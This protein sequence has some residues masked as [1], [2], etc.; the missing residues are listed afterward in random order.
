MYHTLKG[1]L[2]LH[3]APVETPSGKSAVVRK[4][5]TACSVVVGQNIEK[6]CQLLR[7][8]RTGGLTLVCFGE[9]LP[10]PGRSFGK[11]L[12]PSYQ[13]LL[14]AFHCRRDNSEIEI[15]DE[16]MTAQSCSR[17]YE[18]I[19]LPPKHKDEKDEVKSGDHMEPGR[20]RRPK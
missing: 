9:G 20:Q 5:K 19:I 11:N 3:C 12:K 8:I 6:T 14:A 10:S 1:Q 2:G 16:Y 7:Y 15:D 17:C 13:E 4:D 18:K